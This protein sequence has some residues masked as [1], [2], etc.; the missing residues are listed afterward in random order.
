M[1][2]TLL[3]IAKGIATGSGKR[4]QDDEARAQ[5]DLE[6]AIN[7][8]QLEGVTFED[9]QAA[10]SAP[11]AAPVAPDIPGDPGSSTAQRAVLDAAHNAW[12]TIGATPAAD[13]TAVATPAPT[14]K[15]AL[16]AVRATRIN[17]DQAVSPTST[18]P[19]APAAAAPK[20]RS[21]LQIGRAVL[22][23]QDKN[24]VMDPSQTVGGKKRTLDAANTAAHARLLAIDDSVGEFDPTVDYV[25]EE[26]A[27]KK[28]KQVADALVKTGDFTQEQADL[29]AKTGQDLTERSRKTA[30]EEA[31]IAQAKRPK[32]PEPGT[33]AYYAMIR[34]VAKIRS[35]YSRG[36]ANA[37]PEKAKERYVRTRMVQLMKSPG[38]DPDLGTPL[39]GLERDEAI[40]QARGEW[41]AVA[42]PDEE[43]SGSGA[44]SGAASSSTATATTKTQA[45]PQG[46]QS[47]KI[48]TLN[49]QYKAALARGVDEDTAWSVYQSELTKIQA[50]GKSSAAGK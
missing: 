21:V 50:A 43:E 16:D 47:E 31:R 22:G 24:I 40:A 6:N 38:K 48:K 49:A 20:P 29:Y 17:T 15:T 34:Q 35:Q 10:A 45:A 5:R 25:G 46:P 30:L 33:P 11:A 23:G 26:R 27:Y 36:G 13:S 37:D 18:S 9:P 42:G 1:A 4:K 2:S 12:K 32:A 7:L 39:P 8:S 3:A 44:G 41:D 19:A 28:R 14:P